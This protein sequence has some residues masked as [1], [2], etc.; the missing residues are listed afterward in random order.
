MSNEG[1]VPGGENPARLLAEMFPEMMRRLAEASSAAILNGP[2]PPGTDGKPADLGPAGGDVLQFL[3]QAW[4]AHVASGLRYWSRVADAWATAL[5][6][7]AKTLAEAAGAPADGSETRAIL[8]DELRGR[9]REMADYPS[10]ELRV[11]QAELDRIAAGLWPAPGPNPEG[12]YWRR[13][14]AKP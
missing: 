6:S 14:E 4:L 9:L 8:V 10:Q 11:L 7:L 3:A 5:P 1:F 12:R 2:P 13:W